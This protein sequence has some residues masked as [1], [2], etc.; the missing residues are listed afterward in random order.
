MTKNVHFTCLYCAEPPIDVKEERTSLVN[1][2][3]YT[4]LRTRAQ[5]RAYR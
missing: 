1:S 2:S 5:V 4:S 3:V